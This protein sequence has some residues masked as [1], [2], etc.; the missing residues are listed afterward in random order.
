V[1]CR[2]CVTMV[3]LPFSSIVKSIFVGGERIVCCVQSG[4]VL[5]V[6]LVMLG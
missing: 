2:V 5:S 1:S 4:S 3:G 6:C